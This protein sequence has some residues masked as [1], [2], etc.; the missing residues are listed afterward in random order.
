MILIKKTFKPSLS[1][2]KMKSLIFEHDDYHWQIEQDA[3]TDLWNI[4]L[5][6]GEG[7]S[8]VDSRSSLKVAKSFVVLN[9]QYIIQKYVQ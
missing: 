4:Y 2:T 1:K 6:H 3:I 7:R 9:S 5:H 8:Y